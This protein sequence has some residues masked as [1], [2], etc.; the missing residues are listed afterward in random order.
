MEFISF[1][2][3]SQ[4]KKKYQFETNKYISDYHEEHAGI[5]FTT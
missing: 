3:S 2:D 4:R 5:D 1:P